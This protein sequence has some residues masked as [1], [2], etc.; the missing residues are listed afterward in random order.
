MSNDSFSKILAFIG[1]LILGVVTAVLHYVRLL[2]DV[3]T[4]LF[5]GLGVAVSL[6]V[7]L[8]ALLFGSERGWRCICRYAST[9]L[10]A[11][12]LT[13]V[14]SALLLALS[15]ADIPTVVITILLGVWATLAFFALILFCMLVSCFISA[16][17]GCGSSGE[18][19]CGGNA[20]GSNSCGSNACRF[21]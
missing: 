19:H 21:G 1:A 5:I 9:L 2:T 15:T 8:L 3:R 12:V 6:L 17:C 18:N 20:C 4:L 7:F 16:R 13:L 14:A 11:A 10:Y